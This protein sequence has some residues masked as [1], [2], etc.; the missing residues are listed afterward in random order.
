MNS[1]FEL[2]NEERE[3]VGLD[4]VPPHWERVM[5]KD[6]AAYFDGNTLHK[7][8]SCCD[9][10]GYLEV[11]ITLETRDRAFLKPKTTRGKER[12][13]TSAVLVVTERD[14][15]HW[16]HAVFNAEKPYVYCFN[17]RNMR[18]VG[19]WQDDAPRDYDG[20]R[21]YLA[22]W[23]ASLDDVQRQDIAETKSAKRQ[24]VKYAAGDVFRFH[25]GARQYGFGLLL[26]GL[27]QF[28]TWG[29][30]PELHP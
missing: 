10:R 21:A 26:G 29:I 16:F 25:V 17:E 6:T 11:D 18:G 23:R 22:S 28:R 30:L 24:Q 8:F 19:F 5:F 4:A 15:G 13:I 3:S 12:K 1:T 27:K 7:F 20:L 9:A 14:N 2:S